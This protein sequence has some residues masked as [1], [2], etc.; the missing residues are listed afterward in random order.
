M[1]YA[2]GIIDRISPPIVSTVNN[3]AIRVGSLT[4]LGRGMDACR[5]G[6]YAGVI[7]VDIFLDGQQIDIF[8][9]YEQGLT[10]GF[11]FLENPDITKLFEINRCRLAFGDPCIDQVADPAIGLFEQQL[12]QFPGIYSR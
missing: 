2:V 6:F 1:Y 5:V 7:N 10:A 3:T 11:T 8:G 12:I 9:V 4:P